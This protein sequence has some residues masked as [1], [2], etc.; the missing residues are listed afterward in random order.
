MVFDGVLSLLGS[1]RQKPSLECVTISFEGDSVDVALYGA[2]VVSWRTGGTERLWMSSLSRMD[3]SGPIRGGVPIAFPQFADQ[4][5][6]PLHGFARELRWTHLTT[7]SKADCTEARFA[8][9]RFGVPG[10]G[11][12]AL[13]VE[14][15]MGWDHAFE[16][17]YSV[18]VGR[19][20]AT[21]DAFLD[22]E[23]QVKA[24]TAFDFTACLH[25]YLRLDDVRA[26]RLKGLKGR[27][28]W[29]KVANEEKV[30]H[31]DEI[32]VECASVASGGPHPMSGFVDRIYH[33][34]AGAMPLSL[35][36]GPRNAAYGAAY[37][38][39][40]TAAWRDTVV[41]NPW[42]EGKRGPTRGPDF[43]DDGFHYM[44]CV[45]PAVAADRGPVSLAAGEIWAGGQAI[46]VRAA[47]A[48]RS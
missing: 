44:L 3:E 6:L 7:V 15:T 35:S 10:G 32:A 24:L 12:G 2:T 28:F 46:T 11:H 4:G 45:E 42:V 13:S 34:T 25:T 14:D 22:L 37:D 38:L 8:L 29:D 9:R 41:F 48:P 5:S 17:L 19:R 30:E 20:E 23:L 43:D 33:E 1:R 40:Q 21:G 26:A 16:L 47:A 18:S 31:D 36:L 27:T 39:D